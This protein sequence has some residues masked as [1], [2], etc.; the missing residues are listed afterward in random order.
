MALLKNFPLQRPGC[1]PWSRTTVAIST[2]PAL[3]RGPLQNDRGRLPLSTPDTI[4]SGQDLVLGGCS[5]QCLRIVPDVS[6]YLAF[7]SCSSSSRVHSR[8]HDRH[9]I[10]SPQVTIPCKLHKM[11]PFCSIAALD[12]DCGP[13][14]DFGVLIRLDDRHCHVHDGGRLCIPASHRRS[15]CFTRLCFGIS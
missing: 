2:F 5:I 4:L 14:C 12:C 13:L 3:Y 7:L 6:G 1:K 8:T 10:P 9:K 15:R 11:C